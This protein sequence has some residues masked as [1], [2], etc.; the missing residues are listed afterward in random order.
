[1]IAR[2]EALV[3]WFKHSRPQWTRGPYITSATHALITVLGLMPYA[4]GPLG[5]LLY[6]TLG[7]P[8]LWLAAA[9]WTCGWYWRREYRETG[10]KPKSMFHMRDGVQVKRTWGQRWDTWMDALF[11]TFALGGLFWWLL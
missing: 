5:M 1:M 10:L 7:N 9:T 4:V 11:P 8:W 3:Y 2:W 6:F